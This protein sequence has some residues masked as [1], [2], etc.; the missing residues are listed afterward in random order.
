[1]L[2]TATYYRKSAQ[3]GLKEGAL[4][5]AVAFGEARPKGKSKDSLAHR[6]CRRGSCGPRSGNIQNT[7]RR[8]MRKFLMATK[9]ADRRTGNLSDYK[10]R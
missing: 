2:V 9:E 4:E 1:L 10:R 5:M 8:A 3:R 7:R 6:L